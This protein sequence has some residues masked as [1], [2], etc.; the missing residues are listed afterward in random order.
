MKCKDCNEEMNFFLIRVTAKWN[1]KTQDWDREEFENS[2][3][4][5]MCETCHSFSIDESK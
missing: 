4:G 1:D 2:N 3:E 5:L